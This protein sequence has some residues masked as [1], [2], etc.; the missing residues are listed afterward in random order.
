MA[1]LTFFAVII[2]SRYLIDCTTET[3]IV[4]SSY[5]Y[6]LLSMTMHSLL[7]IINSRPLPSNCFFLFEFNFL[8]LFF[9]LFFSCSERLCG[10]SS[11]FDSICLLFLLLAFRAAAADLLWKM[12]KQIQNFLREK[13]SSVSKWVYFILIFY[14]D[15]D[16]LS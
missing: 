12:E 8:L 15:C 9:S 10:R 1:R 7:L 3:G 11:G 4:G 14:L 16:V 2:F 13:K 5:E 6:F